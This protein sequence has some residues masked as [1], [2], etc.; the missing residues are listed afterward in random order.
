MCR[1][2]RHGNNLAYYTQEE[3]ELKDQL[4]NIRKGTNEWYECQDAL[5]GVQDAQAESL[6]TVKEY[7]D[8]INEIADTIQ[9]DILKGF[10][11]ITEEADLLITL[12][13]DNFTD[14]KE[15]II[16]DDGLAA[17][18]LYVTQL[19]VC[20]N[21]VD[22]LRNEIDIM[23]DAVDKNQLSFIDHNGQQ[24]EFASI[25]Q[26]KDKIKDLYSTYRDEVK[27]VYDYESNIINLMKEKYQAESDWLKDLIDKK[28]ESLDA[29]KD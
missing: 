2:R 29:E 19:N 14:D 16:T 28:K 5:Q 3:A 8:A 20:K 23:Q 22:D 12:L 25:D 7:K 27:H 11:D 24:R 17:L 6:S 9:E 10:H 21:A 18:S 1:R 26:I 13:G 4:T 15:G